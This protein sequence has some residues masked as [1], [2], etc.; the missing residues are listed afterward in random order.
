ME[1]ARDIHETTLS[2]LLR[3]AHTALNREVFKRLA[4]RGVAD[5]DV[6]SRHVFPHLRPGGTRLT[7]IAE[8]ADL[9]KQAVGY[10]VD[11]LEA[12]GYVER[13]PDPTDRRAKLVRWTARG[14]E[15]DRIAMESFAETERRWAEVIGADDI[16]KLREVL[17]RLVDY[18]QDQHRVAGEG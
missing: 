6:A 8:R 4:E 3:V 13:V 9:T 12:R 11:A 1:K 2:Y 7:E 16:A 10:L 15:Q 5:V 14:L 18:L 17:E